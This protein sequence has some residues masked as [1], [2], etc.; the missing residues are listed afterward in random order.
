M[1]R[2]LRS[3]NGR[4]TFALCP[5]IW[6]SEQVFEIATEVSLA[7]SCRRR[8]RSARRRRRRRRRPLRLLQ[9]GVRNLNHH[10]KRFNRKIAPGS[11]ALVHLRIYGEA[12][13]QTGQPRGN[14]RR[15]SLALY[16][17]A[18]CVCVRVCVCVSVSGSVCE[19]VCESA[20]VCERERELLRV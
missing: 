18:Q 11:L 15:V 12:A 8:C 9:P 7:R 5:A 16:C 17:C 19:S 3:C 14:L 1:R 2:Q 20:C 13:G 6:T 10:S 4:H